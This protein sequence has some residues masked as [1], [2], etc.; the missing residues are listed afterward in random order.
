MGEGRGDGRTSINAEPRE[1]PCS[2]MGTKGLA[3]TCRIG[4]LSSYVA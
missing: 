3:K 1:P 4:A 2:M